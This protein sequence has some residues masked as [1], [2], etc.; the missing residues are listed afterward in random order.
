MTGRAYHWDILSSRD[1]KT[2]TIVIS[3]KR[4]HESGVVFLVVDWCSL[5]MLE[6]FFR[7]GEARL[8]GFRGHRETTLEIF[9]PAAS[10]VD[11]RATCYQKSEHHHNNHGVLTRV[12]MS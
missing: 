2:K 7:R 1:E 6:E 4:R 5:L 12:R 3:T 11:S 8:G 10:H 9:P